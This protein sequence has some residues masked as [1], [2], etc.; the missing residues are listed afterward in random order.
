M[1]AHEWGA[2]R[3]RKRGERIPSRLHVVSTEPE[4]GLDP[5]SPETPT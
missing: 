4:A 2:G 1:C 5:A 3:E